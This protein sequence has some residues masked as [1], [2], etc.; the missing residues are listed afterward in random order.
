MNRKSAIDKFVGFTACAFIATSASAAVISDFSDGTLQGWLPDPGNF[1]GTL[2]VA[3]GNPNFGMSA[4]DTGPGGIG[5]LV[6]APAQYLGNLT[7]SQGIRW[8]EFLFDYGTSNSFATGFIVRG[9]NGTEYQGGFET[10][11]VRGIWNNRS[12]TFTDADWT[13]RSGTSPLSD[14]LSDVSALLI[15]LDTSSRTNNVVESIVDNIELLNADP[16]SNPVP[17]PSTIWLIFLGL[18]GLA[19]RTGR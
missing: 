10:V 18:T 13:L 5:L 15:G 8:D 9:S 6:R 16:V 2:Q 11:G 17:I 19:R 12:L 14:V 3:A 1:Q 7:S 4:T